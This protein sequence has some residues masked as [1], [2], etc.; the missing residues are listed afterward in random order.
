MTPEIGDIWTF[1]NEYLRLKN[2]PCVLIELV[3]WRR[4]AIPGEYVFNALDL[5][6]NEIVEYIFNDSN[7]RYWSKLA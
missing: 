2:G 5:T 7:I 6:T 4:E 3:K 1:N